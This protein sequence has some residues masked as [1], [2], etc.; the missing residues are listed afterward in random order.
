MTEKQ[1][2]ENWNG[3]PIFTKPIKKWKP[4]LI[5]RLLIKLKIIKDRRYNMSKRDIYIVDEIGQ[6]PRYIKGVDDWKVKK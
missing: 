4:N 5:Q 2:N 3:M 6:F 1:I